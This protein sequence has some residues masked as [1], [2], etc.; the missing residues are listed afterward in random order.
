MV[1][2]TKM[3]FVPTPPKQTWA[4]MSMSIWWWYL[5][6]LR[7]TR[8]GGH[9]HLFL[10]DQRQIGQIMLDTGIRGRDRRVRTHV[11]HWL[12]CCCSSSYRLGQIIALT[13]LF[14]L[15]ANTLGRIDTEGCCFWGRGV[16]LTRGRCYRFFFLTFALLFTHLTLCKWNV[17]RCLQH[18]KTQLLSWETSAR[19]KRRREVSYN[20]FL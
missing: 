12:H 10:V 14:A 11:S 18:W 5:L 19:W 4:V 7:L 17:I 1:D 2:R 20:R 16:L 6:A 8:G 9:R 13:I 3:K 15:D